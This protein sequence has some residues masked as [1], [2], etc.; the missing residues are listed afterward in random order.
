MYPCSVKDVS[1][2]WAPAGHVFI[3]AHVAVANWL[4]AKV[5]RIVVIGRDQ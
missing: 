1:Q 5:V 2:N 4:H 3:L